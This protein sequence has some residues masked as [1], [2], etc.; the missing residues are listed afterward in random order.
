MQAIVMQ[1]LGISTQVPRLPRTT[2]Q[3]PHTHTHTH[4][5]CRRVEGAGAV[6]VI[7][8][9]GFGRYYVQLHVL[10]RSL[11]VRSVIHQACV[12]ACVRAAGH[13]D[14]G[15]A[16]VRACVNVCL[17]ACVRACVRARAG[18]D[19]GTHNDLTDACAMAADT[20]GGQEP[21]PRCPR[22]LLQ[23]PLEEATPV[24]HSAPECGVHARLLSFLLLP[25]TVMTCV[26]TH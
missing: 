25:G 23:G 14:G 16:C 21:D 22:P 11:H 8:F 6:K 19:R 7:C 15:E 18:R 12:R 13:G 1:Q 2:H 26:Q 24:P 4:T 3:T 5:G 9:L 17:P 10:V 20:R